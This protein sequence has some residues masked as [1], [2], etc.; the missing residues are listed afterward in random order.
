MTW[1]D[2]LFSQYIHHP[3]GTPEVPKPGCEPSRMT[4]LFGIPNTISPGKGGILGMGKFE[5]HWFTAQVSRLYYA[6]IVNISG[7]GGPIFSII[8]TEPGHCGIKAQLIYTWMGVTML[9]YDFEFECHIIFI[10]HEIL[11][12]LWIV[13]NYLKN[14]K[15]TAYGPYQNRG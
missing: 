7:F 11:F 9:Q 14:V 13:F 6:Q 3:W 4:L 10:C 1:P 2:E 8:A 12:F 5:N 15:I